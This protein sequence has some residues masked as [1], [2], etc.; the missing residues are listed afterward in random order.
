MTSIF[1]DQEGRLRNGWRTIA[2]FAMYLAISLLLSFP[3]AVLQWLLRKGS[4][5]YD[6]RLGVL[7]SCLA[8]ILATWVCTAIERVPIQSVG[9]FIGRQWFKECLW[10]TLLGF[11]IMAVTALMVRALG[12]FFWGWD[13]QGGVLSSLLGI[14]F[15][16]LVAVH[17]ETVFRGYPFQRLVSSL[18]AWSTLAL[19]AVIFA[20]I[21]WNNPGMSGATKVWA[22]LN[23]ALAGVLLGLCYLKTQSLAL[24]IGVH[25]G[26]N[27]TQGS[28][29]GFG[30]S[31]T[32]ARGLLVPV[33]NAKPLWLSGGKFGLEA[34]LPC[35]VVCTLAILLLLLWKP[36]EPAPEAP[37]E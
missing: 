3:A 36:K 32:E 8:A 18:G 35:T 30:V 2:F 23:I 13:P 1:L 33:F 7:I 4:T 6:A 26:W 17:E 10:G 14:P 19:F 29:L 34:S 27:W 9:L 31:G 25:L 16:L 37:P 12:G 21:H 15:F 28:L 24:P 22:S 5:S 20:F 11:M